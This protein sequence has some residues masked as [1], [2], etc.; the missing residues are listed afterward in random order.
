MWNRVSNAR[1]SQKNGKRRSLEQSQV[2]CRPKR[3]EQ[4]A[5]AQKT[6]NSPRVSVKH[7][8]RLCEGGARCRFV[9]SWAQVSDWLTARSQSGW[10]IRP[11]ASIVLGARGHQ[12][13][14]S[15]PLVGVLASAKQLRKRAPDTVTCVRREELQQGLRGRLCPGKT[16]GAVPLIRAL[17]STADKALMGPEWPSWPTGGGVSWVWAVVAV[18]TA[19]EKIAAWKVFALTCAAPCTGIPP[20]P[21]HP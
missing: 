8:P 7:L 19:L 10:V 13:V 20:S 1:W 9:V 15:F 16:R 3:G 12:V 4:V 14:N 2:C 5:H 11:Q 21:C 18:T 6:L 17:W